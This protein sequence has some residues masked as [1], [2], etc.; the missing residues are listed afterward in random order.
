MS[1]CFDHDA[2]G[3][4]AIE[5]ACRV[6]PDATVITLPCK[7]ANECLIEGKAKAAHKA[8]TFNAAVAKN[9][10]LVWGYSVHEAAKEVAK[11]GLSTP[12]DALTQ[13]T[14]GWRFGETYYLGAGEKMGKSEFVNAI[15]G[16]LITDHGLKVMMAKPEEVN[17]KTYKLLCGKVAGKIFHDPK[18]EFDM[19][20]YEAAGELVKD[21]VC[22][23]DLYQ[24]VNWETLQGDIRAAVN[25]GVKAVFIDPITNL[26]NGLSSSDINSTLQGIAPELSA[27]AKDLDIMIFIFC[28][29]NKPSKGNTPWDR[30]GSI[31][32][33]YFAGSS[34][35]ARSCNYAIGIEGNKDP[36]L[37]LEERNMRKLVMLADREF[38]EC[39][40]VDLYWDY[41]TGLFNEC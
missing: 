14:R 18:I 41:K 7:D 13:M 38:G 15:G 30:G 37:T 40:H 34:A 3:D 5:A 6:F 17:K 29:L 23:L 4:K 9:T 2:P 20:A 31:T 39:G 27:M 11:W 28:H 36:Q 32:T 22:M 8:V 19:N 21:N 16:G 33:D 1:F 26:T 12:W 10:R 35:M 25:E 24:H